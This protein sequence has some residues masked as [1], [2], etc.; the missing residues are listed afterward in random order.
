MTTSTKDTK[1]PWTK[2]DRLLSSPNQ[3]ICEPVQVIIAEYQDT[4][5]RP[6]RRIVDIPELVGAVEKQLGLRV[7]IRGEALGKGVSGMLQRVEQNLYQISFEKSDVWERQRFTVTHELAHLLLHRDLLEV[8]GGITEDRLFRNN[9]MG[10][11]REW[12]ANSLAAA[13]LMPAFCVRAAL[14][15]ELDNPA[16][17]LAWFC[18]VSEQAA[19]IRL[20]Q[21][22]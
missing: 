22:E 11:P 15:S 3:R 2:G 12:E 17:S 20:S 10:A 7:G 16:Q 4:L 13:I 6:P 5:R 18:G 19:T 8:G 21:Y 14:K 9:V 1:F